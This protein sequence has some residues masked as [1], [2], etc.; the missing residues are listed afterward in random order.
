MPMPA[1]L[2]DHP[3][4]SWP[5]ELPKLAVLVLLGPRLGREPA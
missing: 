3:V 2:Y 1:E 4:R 5:R